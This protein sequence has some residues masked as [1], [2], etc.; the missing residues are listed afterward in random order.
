[1]P[2]FGQTVTWACESPSLSDLSNLL[3]EPCS[4]KQLKN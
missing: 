3:V 1:M 4:A 2:G